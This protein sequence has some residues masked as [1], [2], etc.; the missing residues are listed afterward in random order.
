M[1]HANKLYGQLSST[2][3]AIACKHNI[4]NKDTTKIIMQSLLLSRLDYC[5][6][7]LAG[8]PK[9]DN[10]KLQHTQKYGM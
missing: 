10:Q 8:S 2:I 3:H 1:A 7:Q 5:N 6:S 4:L 9:K